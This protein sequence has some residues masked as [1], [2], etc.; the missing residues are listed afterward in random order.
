M[1]ERPGSE[2]ETG[3]EIGLKVV[4]KNPS[5]EVFSGLKPFGCK[6][7]MRTRIEIEMLRV[8]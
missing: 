2:S 6:E 5:S 7:S 1:T 4:P 8:N 3:I